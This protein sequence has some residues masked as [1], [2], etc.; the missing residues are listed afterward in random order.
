MENKTYS[1]IH[2]CGMTT[3]N[4]CCRKIPSSKSPY[5]D[6]KYHW[7]QYETLTTRGPI[8]AIYDKENKSA[9]L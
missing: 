1:N 4:V 5:F 9:Q 7:L 2:V 8:T 6:N 3:C